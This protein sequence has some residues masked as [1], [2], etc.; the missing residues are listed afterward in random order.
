MLLICTGYGFLTH[1]HAHTNIATNPKCKV[2]DFT[3]KW[4]KWH[5]ITGIS[6]FKAFGHTSRHSYEGISRRANTYKEITIAWLFHC[7]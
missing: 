2:T 4:L 5:I 6:K 7:I 3:G 1:T